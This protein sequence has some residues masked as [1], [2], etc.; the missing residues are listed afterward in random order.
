MLFTEGGNK[1]FS[2]N[3]GRKDSKRKKEVRYSLTY[4]FLSSWPSTQKNKCA[5]NI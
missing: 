2:S 5:Y 3:T 4:L 1:E